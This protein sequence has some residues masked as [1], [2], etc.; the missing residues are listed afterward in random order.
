[1][2]IVE[3]GVCMCVCVYVCVRAVCVYGEKER[4]GGCCVALFCFAPLSP[5]LETHTPHTRSHTQTHT[6]TH[7]H[8]HTQTYARARA[9]THTPVEERRL[10]GAE[11]PHEQNNWCLRHVLT[12]ACLT[13]N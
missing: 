3:E 9:H 1:M 2:S 8:T 5:I 12:V 13:A 11:K 4:K 10:A 6:H 7:T